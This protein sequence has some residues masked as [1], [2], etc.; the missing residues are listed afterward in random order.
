MMNLDLDHFLEEVPKGWYD[1]VVDTHKRIIA[2][3]PDY[4]I[5]QIKQK[6]G[7]L[8]YYYEASRSTAVIEIDRIIRTAE[9]VSSVICQDCGNVSGKMRTIKSWYQTLCDTCNDKRS[10]Q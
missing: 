4:R 6:F 5:R 1:L 9:I 10:K 2:I 7:N 3:D 8:R